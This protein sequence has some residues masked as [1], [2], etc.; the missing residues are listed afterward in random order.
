MNNTSEVALLNASRDAA[1]DFLKGFLVEIMVIYHI[2]NYYFEIR[3][4]I[5]LYIDFV[6]GSFVFISGYL[7]SS[8][9]K[10][11]YQKDLR[12][13][14]FRLFSRGGKLLLLFLLV[15]FAIYSA[16]IKNYNGYEFKMNQLITNLGSILLAGSAKISSF[17]LL[18]PI[19]YTLL[20]SSF[21]VLISKKTVIILPI[22]ALVIC[23]S[24]FVSQDNFFNLYYISI[25]LSGVAL[26]FFAGFI[27]RSSQ[28]TLA[29]ILSIISVIAYYLII[30]IRGRDNV[31]PYIF[32]IISV[33]YC[34][35]SFASLFTSRNLIINIFNILGRYTLICYLAQ[36]LFLQILYRTIGG[37]VSTAISLSVAFLTTN[38]FLYIM[39][40]VIKR[41]CSINKYIDKAYLLFFG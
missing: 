26:G 10:S 35:Y 37:S 4:P 20:L 7:V 13:I 21:L 40:R 25:G 18:V 14:F 24:L 17:E 5:L 6:T 27:H 22:I 36:I 28:T 12:K 41:L 8:V 9:Y 16:A 34:V 23:V 31:L 29:K 15:N 19:A 11:K 33:L 2:F 3:P 1:L 32:G 39:C 38:L 30:T